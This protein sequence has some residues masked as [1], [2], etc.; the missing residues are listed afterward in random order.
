MESEA[1]SVIDE[2]LGPV[3]N[4]LRILAV[5]EVDVTILVVRSQ[6]FICNPVSFGYCSMGNRA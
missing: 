5:V 6:V 2:E 1:S 4:P 3:V